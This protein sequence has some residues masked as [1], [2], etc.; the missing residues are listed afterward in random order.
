MTGIGLSIAG[1]VAGAMTF[2][3]MNLVSRRRPVWFVSAKSIRLADERVM[4]ADLAL[5]E[6]RLK[7]EQTKRKEAETS[8]AEARA[9]L[10]QER[11]YRIKDRR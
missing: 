2:V 6:L 4:V 10:A 8:A 3:L 9:D 11:L 1:T 5:M 7:R